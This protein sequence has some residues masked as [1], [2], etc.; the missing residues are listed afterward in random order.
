MHIRLSATHSGEINV[1]K[2]CCTM[3]RNIFAESLCQKPGGLEGTKRRAPVSKVNTFHTGARTRV[4]ASGQEPHE[5]GLQPSS[6][7]V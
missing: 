1:L 4:V 2:V 7:S 6:I 3:A 5:L